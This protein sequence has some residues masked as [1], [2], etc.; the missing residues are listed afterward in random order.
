VVRI[1]GTDQVRV[2]GTRN[3]EAEWRDL[4]GNCGNGVTVHLVINGMS[5]FSD[6]IATTMST[7]APATTSVKHNAVVSAGG[8]IDFVVGSN[9]QW[10][11][12]GTGLT[13]TVS[14][15]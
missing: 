5:A 8:F 1:S 10:G 4:D 14:R 2:F 7:V 12:D 13:A 9:G 3:I 6:T 11:C 15:M